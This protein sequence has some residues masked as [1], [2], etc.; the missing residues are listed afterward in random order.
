MEKNAK[1][2]PFFYKERKRMQR[3]FCSFIKNGK[4]RKDRSVILK[5]TDAQPCYLDMQALNCAKKIFAK[6]KNVCV[7][8]LTYLLV[9][10]LGVSFKNRVK[11]LETLSLY[12]LKII[13]YFTVSKDFLCA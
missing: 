10:R 7:T 1:I 8:V 6:I 12:A 5:R 11:N 3:L 9:A 2:V 13:L 4:E